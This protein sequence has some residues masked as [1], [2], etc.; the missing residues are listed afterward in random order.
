MVDTLIL[1]LIAT[2]LLIGAASLAGRRWGPAVGGWFVGLP[3]TSGPIALFL[4][5][6]HGASFASAAAV[7]SLTGALAEAAFC[8]AYAA[9]ARTGWP[10]ALAIA[11]AAFTLTAALLQYAALSATAAAIAAFAALVVALALLPR[12]PAAAPP[13]AA[14]AWDL[15][16]RMII[17]TVLVLA[18]TGAAA[19]L[20]PRLSGVL[21]TFPVYAAILTIFAHRASAAAAVQVLRGLV[22]GLFAF[23]GF[24]VVLGA[25]IEPLGLAAG[26]ALATAAALAIQGTSLALVVAMPVSGR[27]GRILARR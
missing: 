2:P 24:F 18:I 12:R 8:L 1:K 7:G 11:T 16:A 5:L 14:P 15:P 6:D 27:L 22:L 23:A 20:G 13:S 21:A 25:L 17:T 4:A 26:F 10:G 19:T 9:A 3:L